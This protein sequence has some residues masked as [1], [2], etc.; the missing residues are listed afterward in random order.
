MNKQ[1]KKPE[2]SQPL[3]DQVL[4]RMLAMKPDPKNSTQKKKPTRPKKQKKS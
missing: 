2:P 1:Q 3:E 4:S